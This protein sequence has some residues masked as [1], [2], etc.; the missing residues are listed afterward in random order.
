MKSRAV[1]SINANSMAGP[2]IESFR[3]RT[4][5]LLPLATLPAPS[6]AR[7][8]LALDVNLPYLSS[9]SL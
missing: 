4:A 8:V 6:L 2:K 3:Q 1:Q 9:L 7:V 5:V